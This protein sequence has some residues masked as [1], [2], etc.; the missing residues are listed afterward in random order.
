[1]TVR[2]LWIVMKRNRLSMFGIEYST[3]LIVCGNGLMQ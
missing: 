2:Y 3:W 1:M